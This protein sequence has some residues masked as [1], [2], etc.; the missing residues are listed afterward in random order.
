[1]LREQL[2]GSATLSELL[3]LANEGTTLLRNVCTV[4]VY[5]SPR[6]NIPKEM[7]CHWWSSYLNATQRRFFSR[8][9]LEL[10]KIWNNFAEYKPNLFSTI[11]YRTLT[12]HH[13][14]RYS[15]WLHV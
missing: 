13:A 4:H 2:R 15:A 8:I 1:M 14:V 10:R 6:H 3:D 7:N 5:Q 9:I 12:S 11:L